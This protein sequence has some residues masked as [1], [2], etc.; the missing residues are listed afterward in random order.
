MAA[1]RARVADP[2]RPGHDER[3]ARA[4][5]VRGDLLAPVKRGVAGPRPSGRVV[6]GELVVAPRLEAAVLEQKTHLLLGG[7]RDPVQRRQ[8]IER[9]CERALHARAVVTPDPHHYGVLE[10]AHLVDRVDDPADV[11]VGVLGIAGVDLHL[12]GVEAL[13]R[14]VERV[15]GR[16]RVVTRRQ[17]SVGGHDAQFLLSSEGLLAHDVPALVELALVLIRPLARDM[18][19]GVAAAG[20]DVGEPRRLLLLGANPVKPVDRL[21]GQVVLE[22]VLLTVLSLRDADDLLVLRDQRV[23]LPGLTA[24]EPPEVIKSEPGRPPIEWPRE[25][26]LIVRSQMPLPEASGQVAVLLQ[27]PWKRRAIARDGRVVSRERTGELAHHAKAHPMV[28]AP[29]EQRCSRRRAERCDVKAVVTQP[30]LRKPR[31]VRSLDR[32]PE[33]ARVAKACVVD[34]DEKH[35]RRA[36]GRLNVPCLVPIGL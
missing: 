9:P 24:E 27:H 16:E 19:G 10:L 32:A 8:L 36:L 18:V 15:P 23:V 6:R 29:R 33:R 3:V 17:L 30:V 1:N 14:L 31:V 26:L 20:R 21:I 12:A 13:V 28:V 2:A 4:A 11:P 34:Q 22:V 35:I 5:K 25:P 7:E